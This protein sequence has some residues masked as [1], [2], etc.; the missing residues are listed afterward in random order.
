MA[1]FSFNVLHNFEPTRDSYGFA[2][3]PQYAQRYREYFSIYK[4]EED[5]RS[6]KWSDFLEHVAESSQPTS[7]EHKE[8]LKAEPK[9]DEVKEERSPDRPNNGDDSSRTMLCELEEETNAISVSEGDDSN[10]KKSAEGNVKIEE[11]IQDRVSKGGDSNTSG[12]T[13]IKEG[14]NPGRV[15]EGG[16][17]SDKNFISDSATGNI[18]GKELHHSEERKTRKVVQHWAEIRPSLIA[19]EEIFSSRVKGKKMKGAEINRNN[20]H[21]PSIDESKPVDDGINGSK[22]ENSLV[23]QDLPELLSRWKELESLVQGGVPKDLRGE[24]WQAFVGVK[25]RRVES[26]YEDL[27]AHNESEEQNVSSAA[28]GKWKKQIEKVI[29][30]MRLGLYFDLTYHELSQVTLL[31]MKMAEIP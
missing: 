27:L 12:D 21:L 11:T 6:D 5:E 24:V 2:L 23:D 28:F 22:E 26:Y 16:D 10:G 3:R 13:E 18:S 4:E 7:S 17:S 20:N 14:T 31:W 30:C 15:S 9:S 8:T 29:S 1:H 25:T 19:I